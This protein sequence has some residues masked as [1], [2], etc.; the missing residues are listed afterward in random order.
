[1][2]ERYKLDRRQVE[3]AHFQFAILQV[4]SWYPQHLDICK[5]PLHSGLDDTVSLVLSRYHG[6]FMARNAG[7]SSI[8]MNAL[9]PS[10]IYGISFM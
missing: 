3:T 6:A 2:L 5:L 9:P 1:M 8:N 10:Y 4:A 7:K